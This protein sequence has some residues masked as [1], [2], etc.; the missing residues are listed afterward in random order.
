MTERLVLSF[1]AGAAVLSLLVFGLCAA[2]FARTPWLLLATAGVGAGFVWARPI[3][4]QAPAG[5][6]PRRLGWLLAAIAVPFALLYIV[7]AAAPEISPDGSYYHL[8]LVRRYLNYG[9]FNRALNGFYANLSQGCDMLF[10]AAYAVGRHS[11]AAL[12]HCAF[13]LALPAAMIAYGQRFALEMAAVVGALL[14]FVAP[15]AGVDGSSAYVDIALAFSGFAMF[16]ALEIW[17]TE[18][19]DSRW[20]ALAGLLGGFC[21]AIKFTGG[22]AICFAAGYVLLRTRSARALATLLAPAAVMALPWLIKAWVFTGN[23]FSPV[24]NRLFPNPYIHIAF[25]QELQESMRHFNGASIGWTTPWELTVRGGLLQGTLGPAF[26][27]APIAILAL[28]EARGRRLLAA[29]AVFALPWL[30]NIGTRFLI[31]ALPFLALAM[32]IALASRPR[33]A[34]LIVVLNAMACWPAI[35]GLYCAPY[36]WRLTRFPIAAALRIMPQQQFLETYAPEVRFARLLQDSVPP[37]GV[38]YTAQP[39]MMSYTDRTVLLNWESARAQRVADQL[40]T[41]IDPALQPS[42]QVRFDYP[43]IVGSRLR[44][45]ATGPAPSWTVNEIGN[46]PVRVTAEPNRW[47]AP[48]AADGL[49]ITAWR[50]WQSVERGMCIEA[51]FKSGESDSFAFRTRDAR[52]LPPLRLDIQMADGAWRS[53]GSRPAIEAGLPM[54]DLRAE[55]AEA[56][57]REGVTHL[58]I[59]DDEPLGPEIRD[60]QHEWNVHSDGEAL[61]LRLYRVLPR[62]TVSKPLTTARNAETIRSKSVF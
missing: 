9:G 55:A 30:T 54:P 11:A 21:F 24:F 35:L 37:S 2:G 33:V 36:C 7:N 19:G 8:G 26:L 45:V 28:R 12:V 40:A 31:P 62:E 34:M 6:I 52:Q 1:G 38:V 25:E 22:V 17:D 14:V 46:S 47:D 43:P 49:L 27:L 51:E 48:L 39:I 20:L 32:G 56:L 60:H 50:S 29:S 3:P 4:V 15:V 58:L 59:H 18:R 57:R 10:L 5:R 13:L 61:P 16:Y 42:T 53:T 23:P 41:V 44:V